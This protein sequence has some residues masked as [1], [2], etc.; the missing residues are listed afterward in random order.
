[1]VATRSHGVQLL[2]ALMWGFVAVVAWSFSSAL[3][4]VTP[5]IAWCG[6]ALAFLCLYRT[7][8]SLLGWVTTGF[9]L[10]THRLVVRRGLMAQTDISIPLRTV[11]GMTVGRRSL[12][13]LVAAG[14]VHV[15]SRGLEH[16]LR[17][18]PDPERFSRSAQQSQERLLRSQ[19]IYSF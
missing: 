9:V 11:E 5:W 8:R 15:H 17:G 19:G 1:M 13:G 12:M 14:H 7:L 2:P 18:V 6:L 4:V 3:W 10:T 16:V